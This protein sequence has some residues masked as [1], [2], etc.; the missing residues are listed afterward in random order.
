MLNM[1]IVGLGGFIGAI[2]RYA[3][4]GWVQDWSKSVGFPYGTLAV[5]LLGCLLIGWLSQLA[6]SRNLFNPEFRLLVFIGLLGAFTTFSTF[7]LETMTLLRDNRVILALSNVMVHVV[8]GL[9]MV[10]V[11][12]LIARLIW[13]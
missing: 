4:G 2:F 10:W 1:L 12:R 3:L 8:F 13:R 6:D 9:G 7:G 5:N 11:G